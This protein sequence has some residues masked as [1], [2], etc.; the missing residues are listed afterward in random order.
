MK[1]NIKI[2]ALVVA[3]NEENKL[4]SCLKKLVYADELVVVLDK[5]NDKSEIIAKKFGAKVYKGSWNIEANRRNFGIKKC[6][7][8]W[9]LEIDADEHVPKELFTEIRKKIKNAE[10][11]YFLIPFDNYIGKRRIRYGWGASWVFLLL[12]GYILKVTN[13]EKR[14]LIHPQYLNGKKMWLK[15]RIQ[16]YVDEDLND[17]IMRLIRYTDLKAIDI[18]KQ[19]KKIPHFLITIRRGI[20][21]FLKCFISRKGYKEGKWGFIIALMA[22]LYII[23][24]YVKATEIREKK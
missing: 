12:Q 7:G 11:G 10:P 18:A 1:N 22:S 20:T 17:M 3:H 21:R 23:L 13:L 8:D 24:S 6:L 19:N 4:A 2:S 16:H 5:T 9:I 15:S 14:Q